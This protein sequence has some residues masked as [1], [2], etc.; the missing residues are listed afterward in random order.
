MAKMHRFMSGFAAGLAAIVLLAGPVAPV[1]ADDSFEGSASASSATAA[2]T[3]ET[4]ETAASAEAAEQEP[5]GSASAPAAAAI[6]SITVAHPVI[7]RFAYDGELTEADV[8]RLAGA[9]VPDGYAIGVDAQALDLLNTA[10]WDYTAADVTVT[11]TVLRDGEPVPG[12]STASVRVVVSAPGRPSPIVERHAITVRAADGA[13]SERGLLDAAGAR[14]GVPDATVGIDADQVAEVNRT[15]AANGAGPVDVVVKGARFGVTGT[16]TVTVS[17]TPAAFDAHGFDWRIADG[18][19][20]GDQVVSLAEASLPGEGYRFDVPADQLRA[21][22]DSIRAHRAG[23]VDLEL[24]ALRDDVSGAPDVTR[25]VRIRLVGDATMRDAVAGGTV[26]TD[27][28]EPSTT[29][30]LAATGAAVAWPIA[31]L[32]AAA[33]LGLGLMAF[34]SAVARRMR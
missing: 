10:Y 7:E 29:G 17:V 12:A 6:P 14:P 28:P 27:A 18:Q 25:T 2:I 31:V 5:Q 19:L 33:A 26:Q 23:T 34:P 15:I 30:T 3:T 13:V 4:A 8:I 20:T 9:T 21:V 22:N 32:I 11:L 24:T 16:Q 1:L